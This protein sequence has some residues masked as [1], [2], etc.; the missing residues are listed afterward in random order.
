[1]H[2]HVHLFQS[3]VRAGMYKNGYMTLRINQANS[4]VAETR[5]KLDDGI[6]SWAMTIMNGFVKDIFERIAGKAS[7]LTQYNKNSRVLSQLHSSVRHCTLVFQ[8]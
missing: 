6:S 3:C 4:N 1:M 7:H 5:L 2:L 8:K